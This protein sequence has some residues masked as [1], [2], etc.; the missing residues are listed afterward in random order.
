MTDVHPFGRRDFLFSG[1]LTFLVSAL[2]GG[3]PAPREAGSGPCA[4]ARSQAVLA[5]PSEPGARLRVNGR[6]F[7]PDGQTPAVGTIVYAYQT[8]AEGYYNRDRGSRPRLQA[9]MRTDEQGRFGY[10]TI[11]PGWYPGSTIPAHVHHQAWGGG[12]PTQYLSDL[13]FADDPFISAADRAASDRAGSFAWILQPR[14]ESGLL[15]VDLNLRLKPAADAIGSNVR[16]GVEACG[17]G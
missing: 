9:W 10:D 8:D 12:V 13:N 5:P 17:L 2:R 16:H 14:S 6:L 3:A 11:R 1:G 15:G 7:A 4:T